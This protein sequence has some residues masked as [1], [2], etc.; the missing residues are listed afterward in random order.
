MPVQ[1][2]LLNSGVLVPFLSAVTDR[3]LRNKRGAAYPHGKYTCIVDL[4]VASTTHFPK[5]SLN[6]T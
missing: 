3:V 4:K 1:L 6:Y 2:V 5:F